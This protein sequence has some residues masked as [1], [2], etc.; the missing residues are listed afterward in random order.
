MDVV[1]LIAGILLLLVPLGVFVYMVADCLS[2]KEAIA[3]LFAI[4]GIMGC[5][6]FGLLLIAMAI[7]PM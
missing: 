3:I 4:L 2:W 5:I 7:V 1:T 6:F